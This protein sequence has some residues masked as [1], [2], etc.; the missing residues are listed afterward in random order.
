MQC[1]LW[2]SFSITVHRF[3]HISFKIPSLQ[4]SLGVVVFVNLLQLALG[5]CV[6]G[7]ST[8]RVIKVQYC[9]YCHGEINSEFNICTIV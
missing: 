3:L 6:V 9:C 1:C 4:L 2:V 5:M 7:N 8:K